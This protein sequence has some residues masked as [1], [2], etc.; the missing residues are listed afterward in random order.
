MSITKDEIK[1]GDILVNNDPR[2]KGQQEVVV[3]VFEDCVKYRGSYRSSTV[4]F[5]RIFNDS[6]VRSVGYNLK[7]T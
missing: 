2:K 1:V 4:R 3:A 6:T 7:H 5:S